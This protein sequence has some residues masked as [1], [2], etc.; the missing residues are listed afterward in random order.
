MAAHGSNLAQV[1][2]GLLLLLAGLTGTAALIAVTYGDSAAS[3]ALALRLG[4]TLS[5]LLSAVAQTTVLLGAWLL[6]R[7]NHRER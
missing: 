5:L 2:F 7:S 3:Q 4:L 6:W 1:I